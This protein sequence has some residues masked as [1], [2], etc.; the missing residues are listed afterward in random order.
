MNSTHVQLRLTTSRQMTVRTS[1][2]RTLFSILISG[3]LL[4]KST[5]TKMN[6]YWV[7]D[8][9]R[10]FRHY[11]PSF[12]SSN[13]IMTHAGSNLRSARAQCI[14][15]F[16]LSCRPFLRPLNILATNSD[17]PSTQLGSL[18]L[19][20][21][22]SRLQHRCGFAVGRPPTYPPTHPPD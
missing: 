2:F 12:H 14:V 21:T 1:L 20:S 9:V 13:S 8:H 6:H 7:T 3:I 15:Y 10:L 17:H 4:I 16:S 22:D 11:R 18:L 19:M 5:R